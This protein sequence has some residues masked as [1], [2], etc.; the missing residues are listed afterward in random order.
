MRSF[1]VM[2]GKNVGRRPRARTG[3]A[4]L[5]DYFMLA[6]LYWYFTLTS[7]LYLLASK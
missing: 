5:P 3:S 7:P 2:R 1:N 4:P 6:M